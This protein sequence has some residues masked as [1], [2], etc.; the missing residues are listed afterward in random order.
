[1]ESSSLRFGHYST[2][3]E[4]SINLRRL[5]TCHEPIQS[6]RC[7]TCRTGPASSEVNG[8]RFLRAEASEGSHLRVLLRLDLAT[9]P[10]RLVGNRRTI[11]GWPEGFES[12]RGS[13]WNDRA[14][15]IASAAPAGSGASEHPGVLPRI[16]LV[17][18]RFQ[19]GSFVLHIVPATGICVL[20]LSVTTPQR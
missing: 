10:P 16:A 11:A 2:D 12:L 20:E 18:R 15:V 3:C 5:V 6:S 8:H 13:C 9:G 7:L 19:S 17:A 1:C 14:C 4:T